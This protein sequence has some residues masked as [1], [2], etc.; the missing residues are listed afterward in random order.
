MLNKIM[1][2]L[3]VIIMAGSGMTGYYVYKQHQN[4][5]SLTKQLAVSQQENT[6]QVETV[7]NSLDAQLT[8]VDDEVS[9]LKADNAAGLTDLQ[10]QEETD[11]LSLGAQIDDTSTRIS[12][13]NNQFNTDLN[14]VSAQINDI[15]PGLAADK[16][17]N[18][19]NPS[20]VQITD[21]TYTYGAGFLYDTNGHVVTAAHVIEGISNI[22]VILSTA[23]FPKPQ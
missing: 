12:D 9:S 7:K 20:I 8:S 19:V 1:I 18:K 11:K 10:K 15:T 14:S 2:V 16:I 4:I 6:A 17:F 13:L 3:L 5:D 22:S 23:P 21:G